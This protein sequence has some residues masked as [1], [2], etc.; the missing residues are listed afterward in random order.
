MTKKPTSF[1]RAQSA[2]ALERAA[3]AEQAWAE[4]A[5]ETNA[6]N[7]KTARLKALRLERDQKEAAEKPSP[8]KRNRKPRV[9]RAK[10]NY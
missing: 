4:V 10:S 6:Q 8:A 3:E 7:D 1:D 9:R 5:A 2:K